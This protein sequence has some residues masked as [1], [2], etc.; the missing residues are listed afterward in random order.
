MLL[1]PSRDRTARRPPSAS[2]ARIRPL[3]T[4]GSQ[5]SEQSRRR[6]ALVRW[7]PAIGDPLSDISQHVV[8]PERV[9][10]EGPDRSCPTR[11]RGSDH[12]AREPSTSAH[13]R[14]RPLRGTLRR[15][16]Q[17]PRSTSVG[18]FLWAVT[19]GEAA[20]WPSR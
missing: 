13:V 12:E 16:R 4:K 6:S 2:A 9:G 20:I 1:A 8:Q 7:D 17:A 3:S 19:P 14:L 11:S 18:T 10:L 15:S 5:T